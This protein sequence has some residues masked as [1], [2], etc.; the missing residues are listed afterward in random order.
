[1]KRDVDSV[2]DKFVELGGDYARLVFDFIEGREGF[3]PLE[4]VSKDLESYPI[5]L[6]SQNSHFNYQLILTHSNNI[7]MFLNYSFE[8]LRGAKIFV[9]RGMVGETPSV[10]LDNLDCLD[11]VLQEIRAIKGCV[12]PHIS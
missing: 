12:Y 6:Q 11:K 3:S 7:H 9:E 4:L 1:M 5:T 10:D 2:R 8:D